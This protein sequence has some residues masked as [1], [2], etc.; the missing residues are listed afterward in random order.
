MKRE[1]GIQSP[2]SAI[3]P[4]MRSASS[5]ECAAASG[6]GGGRLVSGATGK[7]S[8]TLFGSRTSRA[9]DYS[10]Q[11]RAVLIT[12]AAK[13]IGAAIARTLHGAGANVVLNCHRSRAEAEFVK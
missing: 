8:A 11:L 4:A 12:G 5:R 13:R 3:V 9:A 2:S 7:P 6:G 1:N 10:M